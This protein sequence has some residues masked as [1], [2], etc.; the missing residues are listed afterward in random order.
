MLE[1]DDGRALLSELVTTYPVQ[2]KNVAVFRLGVML[3]ENHVL[4]LDYLPDVLIVLGRILPWLI[5]R[6]APVYSSIR[7]LLHRS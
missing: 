3:F 7:I 2:S 5:T 1:K 6:R 4:F